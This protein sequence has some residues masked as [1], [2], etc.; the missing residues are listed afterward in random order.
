MNLLQQFEKEQQDALLEQRAVPEF[1]PGD[2][3]RVN[4]KV[5]EG[6]RVA[7]PIKLA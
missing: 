5:V 1:G 2:T 3:L 6:T 4:V 7:L